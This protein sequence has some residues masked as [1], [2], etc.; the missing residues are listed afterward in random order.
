MGELH[1]FGQPA[2]ATGE[3][4]QCE[5]D[6]RVDGDIRRRGAV[7]EQLGEREGASGGL[8]E[9]DDVDR[10]ARVLDRRPGG[11]QERRDGDQE[12]GPRAARAG[13]RPRPAVYSGLIP[14]TTPPAVIAP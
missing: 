5:V 14:V 12:S 10:A 2:G 8:V 9:H 4:K 11:R 3:R 1:A 13:P 7:G 6:R